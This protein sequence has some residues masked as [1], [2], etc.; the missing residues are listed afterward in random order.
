MQSVSQFRRKLNLG[1]EW[2]ITNTLTGC[3]FIR[4]VVGKE[5]GYVLFKRED[6]TTVKFH[7]PLAAECTF[8]EGELR[9]KFGPE[10]H[11]IY[12][13]LGRSP[14]EEVTPGFS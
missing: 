5:N 2:K 7:Y 8:E 13:Y 1:S 4:K 6:G 3:Q 14:H 11:V 9:L 10:H 12:R